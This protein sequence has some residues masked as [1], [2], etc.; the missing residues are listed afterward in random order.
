MYLRAETKRGSCSIHSY[1]AAADYSDLLACHDRSII[2]IVECF[3]QIASRKV[4]IGREYTVSRLS[5]DTHEHRKSCAGT[6]K[7]CLELFLFH[8]LVNRR[9]LTD[10]N[11]RL[12]LNA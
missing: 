10:H 9:R 11:V 4:L 6:D 12:K 7:Y 5:R 8:Q 3:H 1:V 2:R